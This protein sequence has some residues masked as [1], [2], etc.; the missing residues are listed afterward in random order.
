[1]LLCFE[2]LS[3]Y[4]ICVRVALS[5]NTFLRVPQTIG[6]FLLS[7]FALFVSRAYRCACSGFCG[8]GNIKSGSVSAVNVA[9][10][11]SACIHHPTQQPGSQIISLRVKT[12]Y[13]PFQ[14]YIYFPKLGLFKACRLSVLM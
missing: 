10:S 8:H 14:T 11:R 4:L 1:M 13:I 12:E 3:H 2:N 6:S 5:H 7:H 9:Q